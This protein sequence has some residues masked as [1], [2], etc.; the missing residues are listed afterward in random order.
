MKERVTLSLFLRHKRGR[1]HYDILVILLI[2]FNAAKELVLFIN[3]KLMRSFFK[4]LSI[5]M[6]LYGT[7][8]AQN[9][10][11]QVLAGGGKEMSAVNGSIE[12]TLGET[13]IQTMNNSSNNT[14]LTNGFHQPVISVTK[15]NQEDDLFGLTVFPNPTS[16]TIHIQFNAIQ[17]NLGIELCDMSGRVLQSN[18]LT[19]QTFDIN[20]SAYAEGVYYLK[21]NQT[22]FYKIIKLH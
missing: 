14:V 17:T 5:M 4:T 2:F 3:N 11:R 20:L 9:I 12:F 19:H 6:G 10:E 21:I 15:L 22:Q 7:I 13:V 18:T 1:S 16:A 8:S